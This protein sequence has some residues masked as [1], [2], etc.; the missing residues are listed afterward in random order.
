[1]ELNASVIGFLCQLFC[2]SAMKIFH[3]VK[4]LIEGCRFCL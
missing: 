4:Q 1:M 3:Y 2:T